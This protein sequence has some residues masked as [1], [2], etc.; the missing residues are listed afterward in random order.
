ME[1]SEVN[2]N[3]IQSKPNPSPTIPVE[4]RFIPKE[5]KQKNTKKQVLRKVKRM[6]AITDTGCQTCMAGEQLLSML[7]LRRNDL[8]PTRVTMV[9]VTQHS[10]KLLGAIQVKIKFMGQSSNQLV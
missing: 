9:G 3:F 5:N 10:L 6:M 1:W 2:G 8:I 7:K 4:I